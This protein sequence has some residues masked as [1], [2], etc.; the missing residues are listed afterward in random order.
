MTRQLFTASL[1]FGLL[2]LCAS[3]AFGQTARNCGPRDAVVT[4]LGDRFGETRQSMGIG[5][6]GQL[7]ELFA[8]PETGSWTIALTLPNG[9]TCLMASGQ[10][11]ETLDENH[12]ANNGPAL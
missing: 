11:F 3:Q 1:G 7:M 9:I 5:A 4:T 2:L 10:S 12:P 6:S 8:S